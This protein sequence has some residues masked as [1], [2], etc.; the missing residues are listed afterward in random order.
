[1]TGSGYDDFRVMARHYG[2]TCGVDAKCAERVSL[3]WFDNY[4]F[5]SAARTRWVVVRT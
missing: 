3:G 1:M 4:R 2:E 5:E